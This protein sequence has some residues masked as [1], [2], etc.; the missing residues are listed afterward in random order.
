MSIFDFENTAIRQAWRSLVVFVGCYFIATR[1][2]V[3]DSPE[4]MVFTAL[5]CLQYTGGASLRRAFHRTAGTL[6]GCAVALGLI[7]LFPGHGGLLFALLILCLTVFFHKIID[8]YLYA[9]S[10]LTI[11]LVLFTALTTHGEQHLAFL[12]I[13]DIVLGACFGTFGAIF[14]W[15]T[16]TRQIFI[17]DFRLSCENIQGILS[18]FQEKSSDAD[19]FNQNRFSFFTN[20]QNTRLRVTEM[21]YEFRFMRVSMESF[22]FVLNNFAC[23]YFSIV[24]MKEKPQLLEKFTSEQ[25]MFLKKSLE[26]AT[27]AFPTKKRDARHL[28]RSKDFFTCKNHIVSCIHDLKEKDAEHPLLPIAEQML[29]FYNALHRLA[30]PW[31][32]E[33]HQEAL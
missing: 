19:G 18:G 29:E 2:L 8:S 15:P 28:L 22:D 5:V 32:G 9:I 13:Y 27:E 25:W 30:I 33:K 31:A 21:F 23:I 10:V 1:I 3:L 6:V 12:R 26:T 24:A 16:S 14:L 11:A 20:L 7:A 17:R 4:W